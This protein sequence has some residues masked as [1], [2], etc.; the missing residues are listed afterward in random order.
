MNRAWRFAAFAVLLITGISWF[1]QPD[2]AGFVGGSAWLMLIVLPSIM[3]VF[4][5]VMP[6]GGGSIARSFPDLL[7]D[8]V[9]LAVGLGVYGALF[10]LIGAWL[11]RPLLIGLFFAFGWEQV[12][13]SVPG[14]VRRFS[15]A[16]YLQSLVPQAMPT[17]G[18]TSILQTFF[19]DTP[20]PWVA[21]AGLA[22]I[23]VGSLTLATRAVE[24]REYVL[25]Q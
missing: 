10:A 1:V 2:T 9:L 21:I 25:E 13:M 19:K 11:K 16:Y 22:V 8:L 23:L 5:L 15:V 7:K 3:L 24:R 12:V 17:D 14:Y 20:S 18:V 4:F 6:I